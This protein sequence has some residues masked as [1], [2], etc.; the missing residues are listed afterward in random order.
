MLV[1][2]LGVDRLKIGSGELTNALLIRS[3]ARSRL[4]PDRLHRNGRDGRPKWRSA[5]SLMAWDSASKRTLPSLEIFGIRRAGGRRAGAALR[6]QVIH[7]EAVSDYPAPLESVNLHTVDHARTVWHGGRLFR[8]HR[9]HAVP[10]AGGDALG[11][12]ASKAFYP[13]LTMDGPTIGPRWSRTSLLD[14]RRHPRRHG[15]AGNTGQT[16]QPSEW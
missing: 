11:A 9:G 10:I 13:G 8:S 2:D 16:L 5:S 12:A 14:G 6:R 1:D 3:A 7:W 4:P 15:R